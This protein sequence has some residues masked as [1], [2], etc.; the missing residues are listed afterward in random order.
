MSVLLMSSPVVF[1]LPRFYP[2]NFI[3]LGRWQLLSMTG[4]SGLLGSLICAW[5]WLVTQEKIC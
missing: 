4:I 3:Q 5:T 2:L 1:Y